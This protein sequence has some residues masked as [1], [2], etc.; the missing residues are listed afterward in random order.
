MLK[1]KRT[2]LIAQLE[3]VRGGLAQRDIIEQAT[4][5]AFK[6]GKVFT[7]NDEVACW[8]PC[9]LG[10]LSD[11]G[12]ALSAARILRLLPQ[13]PDET[14]EVELRA[15]QLSIRGRNRRSKLRVEE[16][17]TLPLDKVVA[18]KKGDWKPLPDTFAEAVSLVEGC[19]STD[20][21]KQTLTYVHMTAKYIEATD[22]EQM[23]RYRMKLP[24]S[25]DHLIRCAG[26]KA[27]AQADPNQMAETDGWVWFR[28]G[29]GAAF[30]C[31]RHQTEDWAT[32][33]QFMDDSS[34]EAAALP[35]GLGPAAMRAQVFSSENVESDLVRLDLVEGKVKITGVSSAGE[36]AEIKQVEYTGPPVSFRCS[37]KL[38]AKLTEKYSECNITENSI[39]VVVGRLTFVVSL[40]DIPE[41][42]S[43]SE[44][45]G[46]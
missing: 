4:C 43:D 8:G 9:P 35:T 38:L 39:R 26:L 41:T 28:N 42:D 7:F 6:G 20:E 34:G 33:D 3:A 29:D 25:E 13:M 15:G 19:A 14:L 30:A 16:K 32:L 45:E 40:H 2:E 18:P 44:E 36:F 23:A 37:P 5:F 27:A 12:F 24:A 31:R 11:D 21:A 22:N 10:D 17:L 1:V 46:E